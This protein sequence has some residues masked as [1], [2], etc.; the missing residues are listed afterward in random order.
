MQTLLSSFALPT[1]FVPKA[2]NYA[3]D[4][5]AY[6]IAARKLVFDPRNLYVGTTVPGEY[7]INP[8]PAAFKISTIISH[9][10]C[11]FPWIELSERISVF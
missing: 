6:Y 5:S 8:H 11:S 1:I 4:F 3:S 10:H 2:P 9:I 7:V